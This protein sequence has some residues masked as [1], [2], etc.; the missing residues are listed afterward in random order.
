MEVIDA[1]TQR[2]CAPRL[3]AG[4]IDHDTSRSTSSALNGHAS[5]APASVAITGI[6][7]PYRDEQRIVVRDVDHV[8]S[9]TTQFWHTTQQSLGA[10][11]EVATLGG[12]ENERL[13]HA[14]RLRERN[15]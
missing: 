4:L 6:D 15:R 1:I 7:V 3:R 11:A 13:D 8:D 9:R 10:F 5:S 2:E 12:I 14:R